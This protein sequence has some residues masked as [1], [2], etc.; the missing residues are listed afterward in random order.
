MFF[1]MLKINVF[2]ADS[3]VSVLDFW[4]QINVF[5]VHW[6]DKHYKYLNWKQSLPV[7]KYAFIF[8]YY[9]LELKWN[10]YQHQLRPQW[11]QIQWIHI[12]LCPTIWSWHFYTINMALN[13]TEQ[14]P[15]LK[16]QTFDLF[17]FL[18]RT[19]K[20]ITLLRII[21]PPAKCTSD[22]FRV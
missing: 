8:D 17:M 13:V 5:D 15:D 21:W 16:V 3:S 12:Q 11:M 9:K 14:F 22:L 1:V 10:L 6:T 2:S 18:L 19:Q 20:I 7:I 4:S